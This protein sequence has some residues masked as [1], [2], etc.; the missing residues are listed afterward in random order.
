MQIL[1]NELAQLRELVQGMQRDQQLLLEDAQRKHEQEAELARLRGETE[2]LRR[3]L[4]LARSK[5]L[6][7]R[8]LGK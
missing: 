8:L 4:A 7:A 2:E 3:E 6:W 5:G 1:Q